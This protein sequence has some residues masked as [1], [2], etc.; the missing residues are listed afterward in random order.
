MV[1]TKT[2]NIDKLSLSQLEALNRETQE[3]MKSLRE[4]AR[5]K[6]RDKVVQMV[7][8]EGF[9]LEEVLGV[10]KLKKSGK[11]VSQPKYRGPEGQEW[12]G[13]GRCPAWMKDGKG[14]RREEFLIST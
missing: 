13:N 10:K 5:F 11:R 8:E 4:E 6:L 14:H 9:T 2:P 7:T 12:S 3:R 1:A